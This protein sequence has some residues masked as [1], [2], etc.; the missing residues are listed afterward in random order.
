VDRISEWVASLTARSPLRYILFHPGK[1]GR[2][3]NFELIEVS[4]P[5]TGQREVIERISTDPA[6]ETLAAL[7]LLDAVAMSDPELTYHRKY[8]IWSKC[9]NKAEIARYLDEPIAARLYE[10]RLS[11][12][13]RILAG[14]LKRGHKAFGYY[15]LD[16]GG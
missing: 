9:S 11:E 3:D 5:G 13:Q 10:E 1:Y 6:N 2:M 7:R 16:G 14:K 8:S 12:Q 15:P 4:A